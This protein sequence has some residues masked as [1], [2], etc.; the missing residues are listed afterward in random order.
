MSRQKRELLILTPIIAALA[1]FP[2]L[3]PGIYYLSA[4]FGLFLYAAL[5]CGWNIFGG[6]TGYMNFGHAAFF[7]VGAYTSALLLL[8]F[9]LSPF[10]TSILGGVFAAVVAAII[11]YPCL[12]LRGPYF[13][14]VTFC[15][16]LAARIVVINVEW[17]GS[18]TGLW[19]PFLKV[20]M[21]TNRLIFYETM[22]A[23]MVVTI[24]LAM[25]I[26]RSKF[27]LGLRAIFYDEDSA[28]TQGVNATKL[29]MASFIVSAFMAG[30]AGGIYGYYRGYIH[31]DFIFDVSISVFVVL[32]ALLG[33]RQSW[34]GPVVGAA[35]LV[36]I[37]EF[38]TAYAAIGAE[39]SRI[40]YGLLLV[41]V[42]M[43]LPEGLTGFVRKKGERAQVRSD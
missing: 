7:G 22:L 31:P 38:L 1:L 5:A 6:Y 14:L 32:M 13:V 27:G 21:F 18:S 36:I 9:G 11:G 39:F 4:L 3:K 40:I 12:R 16:G 23:V 35:I 26:E 41:V 10:Y 34:V 15:L 30:I 17:T 33:G 2:V 37:N 25:W 43:Y 20:S 42:I 29:K 19:L 28:E 24:L 8:R